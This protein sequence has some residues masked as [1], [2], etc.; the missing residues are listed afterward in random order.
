MFKD[1]VGRTPTH[2]DSHQHVHRD[3]VVSR[4][5]R[6]TARSL[7]VSL[8]H[9]DKRITYCGDFYGQ[10]GR[11]EPRHGAITTVHFAE[12]V[13][14]LGAG[15]T[16]LACHPGRPDDPD[17]DRLGSY[18]QERGTELAVLCDPTTRRCLVE[19]GVRLASFAEVSGALR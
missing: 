13:S 14:Q 15:W 16:E 18:G 9:F 17:G 11:G 6:R 12:I 5:T 2:I 10:T 8:R 4:I 1:L 3:E 7:G 19:A